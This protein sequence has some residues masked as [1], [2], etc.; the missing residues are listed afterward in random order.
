M[1][2]VLLADAFQ[3]QAHGGPLAPG[4]DRL[5][6]LLL[7][8]IE[9]DLLDGER[10]IGGRRALLLDH[11]A[12]ALQGVFQLAVELFGLRGER[13]PIVL[14]P[15]DLVVGQQ[16][17]EIGFGAVLADGG[18]DFAR[19]R[20]PL[21]AQLFGF[22]ELGGQLP[23][24]LLVGDAAFLEQR[25]AAAAVA[26]RGTGRASRPR[27]RSALARSRIDLPLLDALHVLVV[28]GPQVI[29]LLE[30]RSTLFLGDRTSAPFPRRARRC[31][32]RRWRTRAGGEPC[33]RGGFR[34]ALPARPAARTGRPSSPGS[35]G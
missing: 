20:G 5:L 33:R 12:A 31:A 14:Q 25:F 26:D 32:A 28:F 8:D 7:D 6:D 4:V 27:L 34:S 3:E 24:F 15:A 17:R 13:F 10:M 2:L 1:L 21:L 9:L 19:G 11:R 18:G 35:P 22:V 16:R 29:E 30:R 23:Q